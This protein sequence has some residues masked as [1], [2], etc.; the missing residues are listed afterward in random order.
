MLTQKRAPWVEALRASII[1]MCAK[2]PMSVGC[3]GPQRVRNAGAPADGV[4][5]ADPTEAVNAKSRIALDVSDLSAFRT[6]A[7]ARRSRFPQR[8]KPGHGHLG[9]HLRPL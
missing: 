5:A 7:C 1:S 6:S 2:K 4:N 8:A 3:V 9:A